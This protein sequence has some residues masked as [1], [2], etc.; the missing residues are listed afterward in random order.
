MENHP[1]ARP[2]PTQDST[3]Q[4]NADTHPCL[5]RDSNPRSQCSRGWRPYVLRPRGHWDRW[6]N[7]NQMLIILL[8]SACKKI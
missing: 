6:V 1:N 4:R 8:C 7:C 3:T 5:K 2:L